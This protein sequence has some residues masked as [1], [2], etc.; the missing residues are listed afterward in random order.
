MKRWKAAAVLCAALLAAEN[1]GIGMLV[2][3]GTAESADN[4][5]EETIEQVEDVEAAVS[6]QD[7]QEIS[8][9]AENGDTQD[10]TGSGDPASSGEE[11]STFC[12]EELTGQDI[13][14]VQQR[15]VSQEV[16]FVTSAIQTA[17]S[18]VNIDMES[19]EIQDFLKA[20]NLFDDD[21]DVA[22]QIPQEV[23]GQ[24]AAV[25]NRIRQ[26][27]QT[28]QNVTAQ[29]NR[30][31]VKLSVEEMTSEEK[32]DHA[33]VYE[34]KNP[35][36]KVNIIYGINLT[37]QD[38]RTEEALK[39]I[40]K[41]SL[42]FPKPEGYGQLKNPQIFT[43]SADGTL[44]ILER[45]EDGTGNFSLEDMEDVSNLIIADVETRVQGITLDEEIKVNAGQQAVI[46]V[47]TE[48]EV[49][50][51]A[52]TLLWESQD[53]AVAE[54]DQD[55]NVTGKKQGSTRITVTVKENPGIRASCLVTVVQGTNAL[56]KS[57]SQ[58]IAETTAYAAS[59]DQNPTV[60]SEWLVLSRARNG[61]SFDSAYFSTYY[62][63]FANYLQE[64]KG[65]L[66][67]S[68]KYTEYSKAI[69]CFTAIGKDA[70]NIAG[71]NLFQPLADFEKTI[72]QGVN[73][74]IWALLALDSNPAYFFPQAETGA[75]Q[76]SREMLINYLMSVEV[77]GGGWTLS[78]T[79]A[80]S[81]LTGMALQALAPYYHKAG[82]ENVTA[83]IDL[84]LE[85]LG[86]MQNPT[87]G[88]S[89]VGVETL[90][91]CAQVLTG[92]CALGIDPETDARF[93]KGG[94]WIVANLISYHVENSGFMHVKSGGANNGGAAA[95]Q[96]N[97]M[98]TGQGF[99]ALVAYQR[100]KN[101]QT[102][103]Y[104]MSDVNLAPGTDG[105][106]SGTG[107][108]TPTPKPAATPK[109]AVTPK[110]SGGK[111]PSGSSSFTDHGDT[112]SSSGTNG[113][114]AGKTPGGQGKS[115]GGQASGKKL[116]TGKSNSG[117]SKDS[118]EEKDKKTSGGWNFQA[119]PYVEQDKATEKTETEADTKDEKE[120]E[121]LQ[122]DEGISFEEADRKNDL[123]SAM[124]GFIGVC[125]G[126]FVTRGLDAMKKRRENKKS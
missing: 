12:Q 80:D 89:T 90:E 40:P 63:H 106:G 45:N 109:P 100:L 21:Y 46:Q 87:G 1:P 117:N 82:Y 121:A 33:S 54:V 124:W 60:G 98:A 112:T 110:P 23:Q 83:G 22:S 14:D 108:V 114:A 75:I 25:R 42:L 105:D 81:D 39:K 9:S 51:Q 27:I 119:E 57:V 8:I 68:T 5:K 104:N 118:Q 31:Y 49:I 50:T 65:V 10:S 88:F 99:Y 78:G 120:Q 66:T 67:T 93:I 84:A 35:G 97:G 76:N 59:I 32:S 16:A 4:Q 111:K 102:S 29:Q 53:P 115:L 47:K 48:P 11:Y 125:A 58:V 17:F 79:V 15:D 71:Y 37:Y 64:N 123:S 38:V 122:E 7:R 3:A 73:G 116:S 70:R 2:Q 86:N 30:W 26:V 55:G 61:E 13:Q 113:S 24:L 92:L 96:V 85:K 52:Y 77:P 28:D 107:I 95:G 126:V 36:S 74:A 56:T 69:L 94:N 72:E 62:N 18:L 43:V 6:G 103:L 20:S 34:N 44:N 19:Q 91:S 101:G 41:V